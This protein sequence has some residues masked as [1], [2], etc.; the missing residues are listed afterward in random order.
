MLKY[1]DLLQTPISTLVNL[2]STLELDFD[3]FAADSIYNHTRATVGSEKASDKKLKTNQ[4]YS[5]YRTANNDIFKWKKELNLKKIR[6]IEEKCQEFMTKSG[7]K[8]IPYGDSLAGK[9]T[10]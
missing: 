2:Y 1:E 9:S 5:T 4:Y 3:I 8:P 10:A 6:E 7:Y